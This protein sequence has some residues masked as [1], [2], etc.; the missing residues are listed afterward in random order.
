MTRKDYKLVASAIK[1]M[2]DNSIRTSDGMKRISGL[3]L[4]AWS[5]AQA[6]Q[7]D[8]DKFNPVTFIKA[9][10]MH[11]D[12]EMLDKWCPSKESVLY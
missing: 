9:C 1:R 3:Q 11:V 10:G 12:K 7:K 6:L 2:Y 4:S 5:I 8:N